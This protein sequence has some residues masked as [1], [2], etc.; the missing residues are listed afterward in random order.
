MKDMGDQIMLQALDA[1]IVN[2]IKKFDVMSIEKEQ[3]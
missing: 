3:P 2:V 1:S